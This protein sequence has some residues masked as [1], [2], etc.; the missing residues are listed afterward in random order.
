MSPTHITFR[1]ICRE[2]NVPP[3]WLERTVLRYQRELGQPMRLGNAR[4]WERGILEKLAK[5]RASEAP[6]KIVV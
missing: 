2:M 4:V 5:I 6:R 1:E 3:T